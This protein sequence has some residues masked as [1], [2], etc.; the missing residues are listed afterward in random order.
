MGETWINQ[1][2]NVLK[3]LGTILYWI[4]RFLVNLLEALVLFLIALPQIIKWVL[5]FTF[6]S[7]IIYSITIRPLIDL[8]TKNNQR[9][10]A[11]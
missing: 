1:T 10:K 3:A 11:V 2:I 7:I 6:G 9:R 5:I 8:L 4:L